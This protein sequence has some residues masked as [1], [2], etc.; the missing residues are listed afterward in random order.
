M[1]WFFVQKPIDLNMRKDIIKL[2]EE[3]HG[4]PCD[5]GEALEWYTKAYE[6]KLKEFSKFAKSI[7]KYS[8][9]IKIDPMFNREYATM[10]LNNLIEYTE[11]IIEHLNRIYDI[12][13]NPDEFFAVKEK[14]GDE[15]IYIIYRIDNENDGPQRYF[16]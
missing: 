16:I 6:I 5:L 7:A 14:V 13:E 11:E 2:M 8:K 12:M 9:K 15:I 10:N 4:E 1:Y 3:D